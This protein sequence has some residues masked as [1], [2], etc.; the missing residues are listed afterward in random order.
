MHKLLAYVGGVFLLLDKEIRLESMYYLINVEGY[1][2]V[3]ETFLFV[4][5]CKITCDI[6]IT[7][8]YRPYYTFL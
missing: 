5:N 1:C 6:K 2:I 8:S 4:T 3:N 7:F